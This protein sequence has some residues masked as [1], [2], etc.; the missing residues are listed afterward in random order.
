MA[1]NGLICSGDTMPLE[2]TVQTTSTPI[3]STNG[4]G[5]TNMGA[6]YLR[7]SNMSNSYVFLSFGSEAKANAGLVLAPKGTP[8]WFVEFNN[9][10]MVYGVLN[11]IVESGTAK[12]AIL[13][14][15]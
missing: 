10:N 1:T 9:D 3:I 2:A 13:V 6:K 5:G 14:G 4:R 7:I 11:G 15:G 8:G 12:L